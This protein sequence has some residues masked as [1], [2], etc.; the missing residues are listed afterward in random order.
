MGKAGR[1][2]AVDLFSWEAIAEQTVTVYM[3][4]EK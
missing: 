2:R 1:Q 4:V 3:S